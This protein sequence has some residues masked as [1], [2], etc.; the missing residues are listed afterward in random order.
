MDGF[1][2]VNILSLAEVAYF[3]AQSNLITRV[4]K[5]PPALAHDRRNITG[6]SHPTEQIL[7]KVVRGD[8]GDRDAH[9][10]ELVNKMV[11]IGSQHRAGN[12]LSREGI[13]KLVFEWVMGD[14]GYDIGVAQILARRMVDTEKFPPRTNASYAR[15]I[16]TQPKNS[17]L[18]RK[19]L[20]SE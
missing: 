7:V 11:E 4:H 20:L 5:Q 19:R 10:F 6:R 15:C 18:K 1:D 14:F 16:Q 13:R 8:R 9:M 17:S 12:R 3:F 2:E